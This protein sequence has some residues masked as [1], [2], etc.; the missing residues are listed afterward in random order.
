MRRQNEVIRV[1]KDFVGILP[2]IA[3]Y[4]PPTDD[5]TVSM[6]LV[7]QQTAAK[8]ANRPAIIFEGREL[9]WQQF[10]EL[11]NQFA[12]LLKQQGLKRGDVVSLF[13]ENRIEMLAATIGASK[14]G[15]TVALINTN[16]RGKQLTHCI[17]ITESAKCL[18][19]EELQDA[20][21][22]VRSDLSLGDG[23][24]LWV[25]DKRVQNE[26]LAVDNPVAPTWTVDVMANLRAMPVVNL[27]DTESIRAGEK[28]LYIFTSGTTGLPKA[29]I[30]YHRRFLASST[31]GWKA[32]LRAKAK[33]RI[34]LCLP[35]YHI[36]GFSLGFGSSLLSGAALVLKR[37]FSARDFWPEVKQHNANMFIYVGELCRYL[38]MQNPQPDEI[39]NPLQ[40]MLG[41]G[42]RP[43]VWDQF[44]SRFKVDRISEIYGSSEGNAS[45]FNLLN[46][47][48]T[49]GTTTASIKLIKYDVDEDEMLRDEHG[50]LIEAKDGDPGL[51]I[52]EIEGR[53][54]FDGYQDED[55]TNSKILRNVKKHGDQWFNTGDLV[56]RIDVGF[57]LGLPHYQF[58]DRIG[59]T[60]RWR[61]E[62]VSTNEVSEILTAFER[63]DIANVYGVEVPSAEGK[64]GMAA[65]TL[66]QASEFD[67]VAFSEFVNEQLPAHARPVFI[68]LQPIVETTGTFKLVKGQL[69]KE[70]YHL[71]QVNNEPIY[72]MKPRHTEYEILDESFYQI[73]QN[74]EA[75]Y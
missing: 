64:A 28:A 42:L 44:R 32:G 3:A 75:G 61:A 48:R 57:A 58:V 6:G 41:N 68:R 19:G 7:F 2:F 55:A 60:F 23:D 12:H 65:I 13:M 71:D 46:K 40:T 49:I 52:A 27:A 39:D 14:I 51:L 45:F 37:K 9:S 70:A 54:A 43:D 20:I 31:V 26:H 18:L 10:N 22:E 33:D 29:A 62:N 36:T 38:T 11:A 8:Y 72:V 56:K 53:Y 21:A 35:L 17:S 73:L 59:D 25:N 69:R 50:Q 1:I 5:K 66:H 34:Y 16:L 63:I 4:K 30:I 15:V 47:D 24:Y 74:G 67:P